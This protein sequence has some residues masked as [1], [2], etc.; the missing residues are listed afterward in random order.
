MRIA[1]I[2]LASLESSLNLVHALNLSMYS[3]PFEKE[4]KSGFFKI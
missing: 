4:F 1:I 2:A 3:I